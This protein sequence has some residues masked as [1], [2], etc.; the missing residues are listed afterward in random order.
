MKVTL[1]KNVYRKRVGWCCSWCG[2]T[3]KT[4]TVETDGR[5][6]GTFHAACKFKALKMH[7]PDYQKVKTA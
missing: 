4:G 1:H 7:N 3:I 5:I 6:P 2:D